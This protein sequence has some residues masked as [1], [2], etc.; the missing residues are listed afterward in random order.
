MAWDDQASRKLCPRICT[1]SGM[2]FPLG[3]FSGNCDPEFASR[4]GCGFPNRAFGKLGPR[5]QPNNGTHFPV[6]LLA[7]LDKHL[8]VQ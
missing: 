2:G 6:E 5:I 8:T 3:P 7:G 4:V 1:Q